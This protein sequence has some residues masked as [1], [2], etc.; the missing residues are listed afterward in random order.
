MPRR[1]QFVLLSVV[2]VFTVGIVSLMV[3]SKRQKAQQAEQYSMLIPPPAPD[4]SPENK[5]RILE[6]LN[7]EPTREEKT[8]LHPKRNE[9]LT[10]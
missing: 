3:W 8:D 2:I 1:H 6:L 5:K 10:D 4:N 7:K 9:G